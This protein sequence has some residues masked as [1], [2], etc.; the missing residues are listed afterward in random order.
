MRMALGV[1]PFVGSAIALYDAWSSANRAVASLLRG[2]VGDGVTEI[3]SVLLSLVDAALDI[4]PG[5][6]ARPNQPK[7]LAR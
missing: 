7:A 2:D 4:L 3:E 1:V 5:V 6:A